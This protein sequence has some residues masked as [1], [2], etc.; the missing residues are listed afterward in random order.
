MPESSFVDPDARVRLERWCATLR[1]RSSTPWTVRVVPTG[2]GPTQVSAATQGPDDRRPALVCLPGFDTC[3]PLW[4]VAD[5]LAPWAVDHRV[6]LVDIVGQPGLSSGRCPSLRGPGFGRWVIEVLDG[7]GLER[8][9]MLGASFGGSLV[10]RL[11]EQAPERIE[12]AILLAPAGLIRTSMHRPTTTWRLL[13]AKFIARSRRRTERMLDLEIINGQPTD[14]EVRALLV[15]VLD[16]I[17]TGFR[18]RSDLPFVLADPSF[19]RL[20]APT[21]VLIGANDRLFDPPKLLARAR[22]V[23][24][25]LQTAEQ[26]PHAGHGLEA[27]P[28]TA[29]RVLEILSQR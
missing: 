25:N 9:T 7:L 26:L 16:L 3:G 21:H 15:E 5:S 8:A 28:A 19:A 22:G 13:S 12:R 24:P 29:R 6:F 4:D 14:P 27:A 2:C 18:N 1:Q 10:V 23:L 11:A 20:T 17:H